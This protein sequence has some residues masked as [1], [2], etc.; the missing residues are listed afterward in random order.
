VFSVC[1]HP[2]GRRFAT[3]SYNGS[4]KIW[5]VITG[6]CLQTLLGHTAEVSGACF[7]ADGQ[8]LASGSTDLTVRLWDVATGKCL[9]VLQ[10]HGNQIWSVAF[11]A[12]FD[13]LGKWANGQVVVS[14]GLD[15][16]IRFWDVSRL[17]LDSESAAEVS[18]TNN[19]KSISGHC[20]KNIQGYG[21]NIRS[22]AC[23]PDGDSQLRWFELESEKWFQPFCSLLEAEPIYLFLLTKL[24]RAPWETHVK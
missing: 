7:S 21:A 3:A 4:V 24:R 2:D 16:S 6:Q 18:L 11:A 10:G 5:D 22:L 23:H 17:P 12:G 1:F 19:L 15:R 20:L 9:K 14:A 8:L 13:R